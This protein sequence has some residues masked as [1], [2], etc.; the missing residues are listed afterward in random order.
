MRSI[1]LKG[2]DLSYKP[3]NLIHKPIKDKIYTNNYSLSKKPIKIKII[4][5]RKN[6]LIQKIFLPPSRKKSHDNSTTYKNPYCIT[7]VNI[8]KEN[9]KKEKHFKKL[10]LLPKIQDNNKYISKKDIYLGL[11][12]FSL[13]INSNSSLSCG[14]MIS[15]DKNNQTKETNE[16]NDK[17]QPHI[18]KLVMKEIVFKKYNS[19]KRGRTFGQ[20]GKLKKH[21]NFP[22]KEENANNMNDIIISND[23]HGNKLLINFD[24][25]WRQRFDKLSFYMQNQR[26]RPLNKRS[27]N[28][29]KELEKNQSIDNTNNTINK[30]KHFRSFQNM[31]KIN[32]PRKISNTINTINKSIYKTENQSKT[33]NTANNPN[34]LNTVN[35]P[36]NNSTK[37]KNKNDDIINLLSETKI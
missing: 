1:L 31:S 14:K 2:M 32:S 8:D 29:N 16:T 34:T 5:P 26:K 12:K 30:Q 20:L 3:N 19:E 9:K 23:F 35:F 21:L 24:E 37:I 18:K 11:N 7:E 28:T 13:N 15:D 33:L 17:N 25:N 22:K 36:Q 4:Y 27:G 10:I 6:S